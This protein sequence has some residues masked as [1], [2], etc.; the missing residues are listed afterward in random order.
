MTMAARSPPGL[1]DVARP[2]AARARWRPLEWA[3]WLLAL[4]SVFLLPGKHLILTEIAILALFA[5]SL[6]LILGMPA[7]SRSAT[8]PISASAPIAPGCSPSTASSPSR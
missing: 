6:D 1:P 8:P 7:S 3:F 4:A 2:L 5:L